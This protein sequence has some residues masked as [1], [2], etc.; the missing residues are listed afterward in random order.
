MFKI[1]IFA[2]IAVLLE[3]ILKNYLGNTATEEDT[4]KTKKYK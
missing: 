4:R 3:R 2:L 1:I